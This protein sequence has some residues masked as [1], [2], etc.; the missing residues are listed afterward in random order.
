M[1]RLRT[2]DQGNR[3]LGGPDAADLHVVLEVLA[4]AGQVQ[5][6]VDAA[7]R[8]VF[9]RSD[10]REQEQLGRVVCA[11]TEQNLALCGE[12]DRPAVSLARNRSEQHTSEL[13]SPTNLA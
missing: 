1:L 8:Q 13:Q 6:D 12:L 5:H 7:S 9:A 11:R 10:A 2:E 3:L 4:H